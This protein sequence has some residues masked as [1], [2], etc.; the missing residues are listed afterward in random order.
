MFKPLRNLSIYG[1]MLVGL[2]YFKNITMIL[3][4][5]DSHSNSMPFTQEPFFGKMPLENKKINSSFLKDHP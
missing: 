5:G 3:K 1:K 2:I 4:G